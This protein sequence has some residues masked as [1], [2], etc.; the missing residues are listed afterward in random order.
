MVLLIDFPDKLQVIRASFVTL[1]ID[2]QLRGCIGTLEAYRPLIVDVVENA[3]SAAFRDPRFP[4]LTSKEFPELD[5][6]ISILSTPESVNVQSE[7]ELLDLLQPG[8]DGL[9]LTEGHHRG[10]FLP[11]VWESLSDKQQFLNHLKQ[12]AGLPANYWSPSIKIEKYNVEE[13]G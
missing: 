12:K 4:A 1:H 10:T 6:H 3:Y 9:I 5:I 8:V 2:Q 13:F 11:S 7:Q